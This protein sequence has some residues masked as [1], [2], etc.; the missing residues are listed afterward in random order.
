MENKEVTEVINEEDELLTEASSEA[1]G[2]L[3]VFDEIVE[4]EKI[5]KG[6]LVINDGT[7]RGVDAAI[8]MRKGT[9]EINGGELSTN[10]NISKSRGYMTAESKEGFEQVGAVIHVDAVAGS[11]IEEGYITINDGILTSLNFHAICITGTKQERGNHKI[12]V[13]INGGKIVSKSGYEA[14]VR[15]SNVYGLFE[16]AEEISETQIKV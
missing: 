6:N 16:T 14:V 5:R 2:D 15:H 8:V 1:E 10:S 7:I 4:K 11:S 13:A 9:L 3:E 12:F